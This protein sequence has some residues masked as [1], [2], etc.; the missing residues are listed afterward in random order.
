M[1]GPRRITVGRFTYHLRPYT[2]KAP[3]AD[4]G[5]GW[6]RKQGG[7]VAEVGQEVRA[8][9]DEIVRLRAENGRI[10]EALGADIVEPVEDAVARGA[11]PHDPRE[12][13]TPDAGGPS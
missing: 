9:L 4:A 2:P 7:A 10:A 12:H 3:G 11:I 8:L 6:V 5:H 1:T 13:A